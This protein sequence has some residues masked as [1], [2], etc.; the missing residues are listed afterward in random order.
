MEMPPS[1]LLSVIE[2]FRPNLEP[3]EAT[4]RDLHQ[5]PELGQQEKRTSA[6]AASHL[7]EA[8]YDVTTNIGGYGL[9]SV[10]RNGEGPIVML[11]ADMDALPIRED[12]GLPYAST[13]EAVDTDGEKKPV[14][15]ACGHDTH[16]ACMMGVSTLLAKAKAKW[17]G[18]LIILFQ[19]DEEH[20]AGAR[21]MLDDNLY[22]RIPR[23][24]IVLGQHLAPFKTG[25]V[26]IRPGVFMASADTF[27]VRIFGRGA[28]GARPQDSIDPIVLAASIIVRLQTVVAREIGPED[29]ASVT[30][31]SVHGGKAHN[32]IPEEVE[33]MINIR[34]FDAVVREKVL[35]AVK[36]IIK[37]EAVASGVVKEPDVELIVSYPLTVNNPE[38]T[39]KLEEAFTSYFDKD[40]TWKAP[41]HTASEDFS[42]LASE[43][44]VPSVFWNFGG[45]DVKKWEKYEKQKDPRL[46]PNS[47]Q[48]DYAPV[49]E[50]LKT[51]IDAMSL[52]ALTFLKSTVDVKN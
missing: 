47:H 39:L 3:F 14:M 45:V 52:A 37:G 23:P 41:R 25:V 38:A 2:E 11:R 26:L 30:C 22:S 27:K 40:H 33:I 50:P 18:T 28:H 42:L 29:V 32:V 13:A 9:A 51:G 21:A 16:V 49:I 12:T 44:N 36:R 35:A 10:L 15:H 4:Y 1:S 46:I 7:R 34:A 20:G 17:S 5:H 6:I 8:G 31:A 43:I 48:A 24:D 19:P